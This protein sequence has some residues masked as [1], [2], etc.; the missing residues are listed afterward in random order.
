MHKIKANEVEKGNLKKTSNVIFKI[1]L[2]DN[3]GVN[4]TPF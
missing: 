4:L 2:F 1:I 3:F